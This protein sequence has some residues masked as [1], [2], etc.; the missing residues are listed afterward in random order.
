MPAAAPMSW[1]G[2]PT[3][4]ERPVLFDHRQDP[5]PTELTLAAFDAETTGNYRDLFGRYGITCA[6]VQTRR[7]LYPA[8]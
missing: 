4:P 3:A 6:L 1:R 5:V 7:P 8:L 2:R